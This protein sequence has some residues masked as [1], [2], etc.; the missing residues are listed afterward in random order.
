MKRLLGLLLV[1][2]MVGCGSR[3][4]TVDAPVIEVDA[5][6]I[7]NRR[8][9]SQELAADTVEE[10][11]TDDPV[12]ALE[13]LG[14]VGRNEEGEVVEFYLYNRRVSNKGLVHLKAGCHGC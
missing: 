10:S 1:L 13:K 9:N 4:S 5:P 2:G 7:E 6:A 12:A 8:N 3:D 11:T 14:G